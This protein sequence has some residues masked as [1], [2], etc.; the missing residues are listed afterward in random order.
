MQRAAV[1]NI[2]HKTSVLSLLSSMLLAFAIT[3]SAQ[4]GGGNPGPCPSGSVPANGS[5]GSPSNASSSGLRSEA[6][7]T[8]YG[9]LAAN[10]DGTVVG[11]ANNQKSYRAAKKLAIK[12]CAEASCEVVVEYRNGCGSVA[13][14]G[15]QRRWLEGS[16]LWVWFGCN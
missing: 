12:K 5:C 7:K 2:K 9:A 16:L 4:H 11:S 13:R 3:V 10:A 15:G 8:Y 6:W 1:L 14:G